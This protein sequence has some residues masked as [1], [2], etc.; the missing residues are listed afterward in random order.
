MRPALITSLL[1]ILAVGMSATAGHGQLDAESPPQPPVEQLAKMRPFFGLYV[2]S[3]QSYAGLAPWSGTLEVG[4]AVKGWYVEWVIN[5]HH[6]AI[7][8]QLRMLMTWDDDLQRYRIWR[9]ETAPQAPRERMEGEA[10]FIGDTLVMEWKDVPG[11][12]GQPP[13]TF[14]N[15]AFMDGED[16]LVIIT[17]VLQRGTSE[18]IRLGEWRN[19]RRM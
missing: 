2:H 1:S 5:T 9:F 4:P 15:R 8:R 18:W 16:E 11:P 13:G 6:A 17:D 19:G 14:R 3:D 10:H 12:R 7:D